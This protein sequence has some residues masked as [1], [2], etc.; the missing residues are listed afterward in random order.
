MVT[1]VYGDFMEKWIFRINLRNAIACS[2]LYS[3]YNV[4]FGTHPWS[5]SSPHNIWVLGI[6]DTLCLGL[7]GLNYNRISQTQA[8]ISTLDHTLPMCSDSVAY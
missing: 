1:F 8:K 2:T 7:A 5:W 3:E 6:L 4:Q